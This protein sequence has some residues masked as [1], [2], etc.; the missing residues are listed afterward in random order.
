MSLPFG[1]MN[2]Q[3][4]FPVLTLSLTQ[5]AISCAAGTDGSIMA[6]AA[7]G[8]GSYQYSKDKGATWQTGNHFERLPAGPYTIYA[9]DNG[10][11][12][13]SA[14]VT[15]TAPLPLAATTKSYA[16]TCS[17]SNNG[18]IVVNAS[19]GTPPYQYFLDNG[20]NW[21]Y[22]PQFN[23][24]GP[25]DHVIYLKDQKTCMTQARANITTPTALT[26]SVQ[27]SPVTCYNR[28]DGRISVIASGGVP[29]YQYSEDK[30][31]TWQ[32]A[33]TFT[34]LSTGPHTIYV[35]DKNGC[36]ASKDATIEAPPP[37]TIQTQNTDISC[38]NGC[39]GRINVQVAGGIAPYRY[40]NNNSFTWQQSP[41]FTNISAG[42]YQVA[43]MDSNG[44][45][46]REKVTLTEPQQLFLSNPKTVFNSATDCDVTLLAS[47]GTPAYRFS[48]DKGA[49]WQASPTFQHIPTGYYNILLQDNNGCSNSLTLT[50]ASAPPLQI[51]VESRGA[52]CFGAANGIFIVDVQ[53]GVPP[54][55]YSIDGGNTWQD[56]NIFRAGA[57]SYTLLVEDKNGK[58]GS[59]DLKLN[60][61][62]LLTA[63]AI[64]TDVS[65]YSAS[66]GVI[67]V[68]TSGGAPPYKFS[69]NDGATW[70]G[71]PVLEGLPGGSYTLRVR[72]ANGC[73]TE[74][75]MVIHEPLPVS[76]TITTDPAT[77]YGSANGSIHVKA[78]GG[79]APYQYSLDNGR[80]WQDGTHFTG[81]TAGIYQLLVRDHNGCAD[82]STATIHQPLP[83]TFTAGAREITCY[84]AANGVVTI[85]AQGGTAPYRYSLDAIHWQSANSFEELSPGSFTIY[86]QDAN[87]CA[88]Q[89]PVTITEPA[90]LS[91][92][93]VGSA[94]G[95]S[96]IGGEIQVTAQGGTVPYA[97][98]I[99]DSNILS[100][101]GI[102][103]DLAAG[104]YQV[105][106]T[107]KNGCTEQLTSPVPITVSPPISLEI[108]DKTDMQCDGIHKGSVTLQAIGGIYPYR[109]ELNGKAIMPGNI[110]GLDNG[111][112]DALV[113]D[114]NGCLAEAHFD[115]LLQNED[116]ELTMPT[117]FSPNGDGR[118][119]LFR[120]AL[121]GN[122][123]RYYLQVFNAWGNLVFVSNDPETGWDGA[124]K[125][126][127]QPSGTYVWVAGYVDH[128]GRAK[129]RRGTVTVVR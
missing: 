48:I 24:V 101:N 6:K 122:I 104:N 67:T 81:L 103:K 37:L 108:T 2:L 127:Q 14:S 32:R 47:G 120:P 90:P 106:V 112:Y 13:V 87:G 56:Q 110:R 75:Q 35:K 117:G 113:T 71:S 124:F 26:V 105:I 7:G 45:I 70:Q 89:G 116:C 31:V 57:G 107:D 84:G 119:D 51:T 5:T 54:Y 125:G 29:P 3:D 83:L 111:R 86:V 50:L 66:N 19:G 39:T 4:T 68:S 30:G 8:S 62:P 38:Y 91:L 64:S 60:E 46:T 99:A 115:I 16:V 100:N 17:G 61:P 128:K 121:F 20:P 25:G 118:N 18:S 126:K 63:S 43:V 80:H 33:P 65:C 102:F 9:K 95:C 93:L 21:Q 129:V 36:V 94:N 27:P 23:E 49:S 69:I 40:S 15:V 28:K 22:E 82:T 76:T 34:Q 114:Q 88:K 73:G 1:N 98:S 58:R 77:C 11:R 52:S 53:H 41:D 109:Y 44:C 74:L 12:Q 92:E 72:D 96:Y 79:T 85:G 59:V 123:S 42:V 78:D 10:G 55:R 97:Y